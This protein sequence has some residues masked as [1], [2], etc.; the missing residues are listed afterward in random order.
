MWKEK[1]LEHASGRVRGFVTELNLHLA[2]LQAEGTASASSADATNANATSLAP[3]QILGEIGK[4][5]DR[6][7]TI[8]RSP[9]KEGVVVNNEERASTAL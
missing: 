5:H 6:L 2:L 8:N 3:G 4:I 9:M 1:G 7:D